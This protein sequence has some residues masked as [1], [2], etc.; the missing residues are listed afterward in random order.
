MCICISFLSSLSEKSKHIPSDSYN[1]PFCIEMH[2]SKSNLVYS[3]LFFMIRKYFSFIS[4]SSVFLLFFF[5]YPLKFNAYGN[6]DITVD[7]L[8]MLC[9]F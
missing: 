4:L 6:K 9:L 3:H 7:N 1:L 8:K 5:S 2:N